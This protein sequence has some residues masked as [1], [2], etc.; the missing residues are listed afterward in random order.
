LYNIKVAG[1]SCKWTYL[2]DGNEVTI[3]SKR[4]SYP[5]APERTAEVVYLLVS[6]IFGKSIMDDSAKLV[7]VISLSGIVTAADRPP[8]FREGTVNGSSGLLF[9]PR[10]FFDLV[11][12]RK[13]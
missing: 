3:S 12:F 9:H 1:A 7:I 11:R 4:A 5:S 8:W 13:L 6:V 2:L 10:W